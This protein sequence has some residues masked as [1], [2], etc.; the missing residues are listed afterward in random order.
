MF[1]RSDALTAA[2]TISGTG[3]VTQAGSGILTL[4]G[5][6]SYT[7][8]TLANAG[9]LMLHGTLAGPVTVAADAAFGG[10]GAI[11]GAL[12]VNG[13]ITVGSAERPLGTLSVDGN[14]TLAPG[15][16][17]VVTIDAAGDHSLLVASG[18]A[19]VSGATISVVPRSGSYSRATFYPVLY[20]GGGVTGTATAT[21]TNTAL[22]PWLTPTGQTL[23]LALLN[24]KLPLASFAATS[25]GRAI[26]D[27]FDRLR[28]DATGDL[29][30]VTRELTALDDAGLSRALDTAAGEIYSS[31]VQFAALDG[32][33]AT[34]LVRQEIASR[35]TFEVGTLTKRPGGDG[36]RMWARL[37]AQHTAFAGASA[38]GGEAQLSGFAAGADRTVAERW[39]V[40][41]GGRYASGSLTLDRR[42]ESGDYTAPRL[43]G[44]VGYTADRWVAHAGTSVA[45]TTYDVRR[46][47]LFTAR[48]PE[49][50]GG[51]P[52]FG[53]VNRR[54]TS[55]PA[56]LATELWG[57]WALLGHLGPWAI[58]P[59]AGLR[60]ARYGRH[61]WTE[62]GADAM[63]LSAGDQAIPS[64]QVDLGIQVARAIGPFGMHASAAYRRELTDGQTA[65]TLQL[66]DRAVGRFR[67]D[68]LAFA[69]D[70]L[71]TRVDATL[72]VKQL[73][74]RSATRRGMLAAER[75]R[76]SSSACHSRLLPEPLVV[77]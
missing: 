55:T 12:T 29:A 34:D 41:I 2:T 61:A 62:S 67:V 51:G 71:T 77:R 64:K 19:V 43:Y 73:G 60:Y 16:R 15:A 52:V 14:V 8:G 24:T 66:S 20:A 42:T 23:V 32:E 21:S 6:H 1:D 50:L 5:A 58:R 13:T 68:G 57:D 48:I 69:P 49:T 72:R 10:T 28:A 70:T 26:G 30:V 76:P 22:E 4:S 53:G 7:G 18:A 54:A 75:A 45:R 9:T 38:Q 33:A 3:V 39:L 36:P 47:L 65:T 46:T 74:C 56:G 63:S 27:A 59:G 17:G 37:Q 25:S 44:Y 11:G 35:G 31:A 40:G